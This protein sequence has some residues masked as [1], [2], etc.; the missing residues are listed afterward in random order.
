MKKGFSIN[1]DMMWIM[2]KIRILFILAVFYLLCEYTLP[3]FGA[4]WVLY[5]LLN[6]INEIIAEVEK[7]QETMEME[8]AD[9]WKNTLPKRKQF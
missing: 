4:A 7:V 1:I 8:R 6:D 9:K 3:V 2:N 5:F